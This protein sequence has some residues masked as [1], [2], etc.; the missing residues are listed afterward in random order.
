MQMCTLDVFIP[1]V[2]L[3][4][5]VPLTPSLKLIDWGSLYIHPIFKVPSGEKHDS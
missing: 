2:K 1:I 5:F 3:K 4:D